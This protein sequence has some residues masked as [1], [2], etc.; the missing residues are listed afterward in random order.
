MELAKAYIPVHIDKNS[1]NLL[2]PLLYQRK[3]QN[4]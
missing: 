3:M 2:K 1:I 4:K